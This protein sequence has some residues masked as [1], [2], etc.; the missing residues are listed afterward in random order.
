MCHRYHL[1]L[2]A[3]ALFLFSAVSTGYAQPVTLWQPVAEHTIQR[4][5]EPFQFPEAHHTYFLDY[6][7]MRIALFAAP[8]ER[9]QQARIAP[10]IIILPTPDGTLAPFAVV[11]SPIMEEGLAAQFPDI[12][13]FSGQG[14]DD[15]TATVRL[16]VGPAGFHAMVLSP[17][18]D[19]FID[20]HNRFDVRHYVV[21]GKRGATPRPENFPNGQC[22]VGPDPAYAEHLRQLARTR[23]TTAVGPQLRTYRLACAATG[24]YTTYHGGTVALGQAAIVTAINRVTG[25]YEKE[26]AVRLTLVANNSSIVY[27]NPSTDPYSNNNGSLMLGQNQSNLDAVIGSANYDIGHVFS[28]GGG[29]V[30]YLGVVCVN[31]SKARGVT[32]LPT[33]V[34]DPFYIDYVA[35]EMGHQFGGNHSFNSTTGSCGGGNRNAATAYEPGSGSTIMAYAGIC[36]ADNL[37]SNSDAYFHTINFDEIVAY[38]TVGSGNNCPTITNTGN[39]APSVNAGTGG[40]TIP[41][42]TPFALTGSATDPDNDPLTYCWEEFDLGPAGSPN[43]PSGNAPISR[44]FTPVATPTRTFP[45][46]SDL[47]NN[48]QTI[49][50]LLP[51]YTRTLTF[52]LTARDNRN[53]GAGVDYSQIQFSVTGSAGPFTVTSPNTSVT[54]PALSQQTITWNVANTN[55]APLNCLN[56]KITLS[57]DGGN[58]FAVTLLASTPNDGSEIVTIPD[59]QTTTARI[60][61]EAIGNIFF[62]IS[63]TNFTIAAPVPIQLASFAGRALPDQTVLLEWMTV[64]E[65]NNYG[66]EIEKAATMSGPFATIAGSFVPGHGTTLVPQFYSYRDTNATPNERYYRLK[67]IDLE[68]TSTH[69]DPIYVGVTSVVLEEGTPQQFALLHNYPNPFNPTTMIRYALPQ[70]AHVRLELYNALGQRIRVVDEGVKQAGYHTAEVDGSTLAAGVYVYRLLADKFVAAKKLLLVK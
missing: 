60:K 59:N 46:L 32:G 38:T 19:Y 48:T 52:R 20:P 25:V 55:V 33:P 4:I 63:N 14:I 21:Y 8:M 45:K 2:H 40:F 41:I 67:Q 16:D 53:G 28:T 10:A 5:G 51:T 18:G 37:Q 65:I 69:F 11:E 12:R 17:N 36:G 39:N 66:F 6:D 24:E 7:A 15:P 68:G 1:A 58:T 64:S 62:D 70:E 61:V 57:T 26:V 47:L 35:H 49:G 23:I 44:S 27:T 54:W 34:G 22:L 9:T 43:N 31:G 30:A 50:E 42:S 3:V 56:V 29:G 13:T